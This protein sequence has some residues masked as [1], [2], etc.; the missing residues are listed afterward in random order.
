MKKTLALFLSLIL[1]TVYTACLHGCAQKLYAESLMDGIEPSKV[2]KAKLTD[3]FSYE[4]MRFAIELLKG[5]TKD[6]GNKNT[7]VSPLSVMLA[8]SMTANGAGGETLEQMEKVLGGGM[9]IDELD[10]YLYSYVSSLPSENKCELSIANSIW[11]RD[12]EKLE[13]KKD[14][15]QKNADYYGA[16]AFKTPFDST[17]KDEINSWVNK[18]TKG[19]IKEILSEPISPEAMMYLINTVAFEAEWMEKYNEYSVRKGNFITSGGKTQ[20]VDML[21]GQESKYISLENGKGFIKDYAGGKYSF[22]AILPDID[23]T[24]EELLMTLD[25]GELNHVILNPEI[26]EVHT[27]M[28]AFET[29]YSVELS[30]ILMDM[31]MNDAFKSGVADLKSIGEC[32]MGNLFIGRVLHKTYIKVDASGT[33]AGAVT[34]VEVKCEGAEP[35]SEP[36]KVYLDRPFLYM[37]VDNSTG[38]PI[39]MGILNSVK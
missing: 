12:T 38:L 17:T 35:P 1:L 39:F 5:T 30:N 19:M 14:F 24:P 25:A 33:K 13:I 2:E 7:M 22:V 10:K 37:I 3:D 31:G 16:D 29:D 21:F 15:L 6:N 23:L 18:N 32:E 36:K 11:F 34:A 27:M 9:S 20:N 26:A 28:P 8:L 4:Q